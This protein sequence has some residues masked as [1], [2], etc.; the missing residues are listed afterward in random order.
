MIGLYEM[1]T[2]EWPFQFDFRPTTPQQAQSQAPGSKEQGQTKTR[3]AE[4]I[5]GDLRL[6]PFLNEAWSIPDLPLETLDLCEG[7][8]QHNLGNQFTLVFAGEGCLSKN[9]GA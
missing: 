2:N 4:G 1:L 8:I 5:T 9:A 3:T 7:M 6:V